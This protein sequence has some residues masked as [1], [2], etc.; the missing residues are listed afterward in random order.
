MMGTIGGI[1]KLVTSFSDCINTVTPLIEN[2]ILDFTIEE[3]KVLVSVLEI[4]KN[5][6]SAV[7]DTVDAVVNTF[8][9]GMM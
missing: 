6:L 9:P 8:F 7:E 2:P 4:Y 5:V 1:Q 3:V